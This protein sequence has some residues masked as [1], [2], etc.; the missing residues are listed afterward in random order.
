MVSE[1]DVFDTFWTTA[2]KKGELQILKDHAGWFDIRRLSPVK[3][4][5]RLGEVFT[6][7]AR[8]CIRRYQDD[9]KRTVFKNGTE[10]DWQPIKR[11]D[12][13]DTS[14]MPE[15][16]QQTYMKKLRGL[17]R[18][19]QFLDACGVPYDFAC[20]F[21]VKEFLFDSSYQRKFSSLPQPVLF[22]QKDMR[23]KLLAAWGEKLR[24]E[25]QYVQDESFIVKEDSNETVREHEN[26]LLQQIKQHKGSSRL[27]KLM[28]GKGYVSEAAARNFMPEAF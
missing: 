18:G 14:N 6:D 11:G 1:L 12:I 7:T 5:A 24:S 16:R 4:T 3:R 27:L 9:A 25:I 20:G 15:A 10:W 23:L 19:R 2:L 13:Y 17:I 22:N 26:F 21:I 8:D 28:I